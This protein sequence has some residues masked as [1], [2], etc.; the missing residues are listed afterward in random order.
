MQ[1]KTNY[2]GWLVVDQ[3]AVLRDISRRTGR[4]PAHQKQYVHHV[5]CRYPDPDVAPAA[6]VVATAL[7]VGEHVDCVLVTV[8][9]AEWSSDPTPRRYHLTLSVADG[10]KPVESNDLV[11]AALAGDPKV[12]VIPFNEPFLISTSPF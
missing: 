3:P 6:T 4:Y 12:T 7:L 9:G 10:H 5:T 8:D 2:S 1:K 11:A